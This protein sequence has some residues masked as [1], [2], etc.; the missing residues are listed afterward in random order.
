METI[1][2]RRN[3]DDSLLFRLCLEEREDILRHKWIESEKAGH[4]IGYE[5]ALLDWVRR[6]R[7]TLFQR[8]RFPFR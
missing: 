3:F 8:S 2:Q 4:D 7:P 5:S 1:C 6:H